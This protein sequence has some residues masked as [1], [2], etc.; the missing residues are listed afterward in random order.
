MR[1][2]LVNGKGQIFGE[3]IESDK[4]PDSEANWKKESGFVI[5]EVK[6]STIENISLK[7]PKDV[8]SYLKTQSEE[9]GI[10]FSDLMNK[11]IMEFVKNQEDFINKSSI[12][13]SLKNNPIELEKFVLSKIEKEIPLTSGTEGEIYKLEI[14]NK[15]YVVIKKRYSNM[16]KN[17]FELLKKAKS[18]Q[19]KISASGNNIKIPI[20][21]GSFVKDNCEYIMMEYIEGKT[22]YTMTLEKILQQD[23]VNYSKQIID[24]NKFKDYLSTIIY[25]MKG[26]EQD[27]INNFHDLS[28]EEILKNITN[29]HGNFKNIDLKNDSISEFVLLHFYKFLYDNRLISK[30]P[31]LLNTKKENVFLVDKYKTYLDKGISV[32][33]NS[34][35]EQIRK[36]ISDFIGK[37]H[38]EGFYHRDL[39]GN[40]R[41]IM[42]KEL[43]NGKYEIYI[44][45]FGKAKE[46]NGVDESVYEDNIAGG[47]F[48]KDEAIISLIGKLSGNK[49]NLKL[50]D[51]ETFSKEESLVK[52]GIEKYKLN[53]STFSPFIKNIISS[54]NKFGLKQVTNIIEKHDVSLKKSSEEYLFLEGVDKIK[55]TEKLKEAIKDSNKLKNRLL[56]YMFFMEDTDF[57]SLGEYI[58]KLKFENIKSKSKINGYKKFFIELYEDIKKI[59]NQK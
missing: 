34:K 3:I 2:K 17:E 48:D 18:I 25:F 37:M 4:K 15:N 36:E 53:K 51:K 5:E 31:D 21:I 49:N 19:E 9:N 57:I 23:F 33:D 16:H 14:Q 20:P 8:L 29:K 52:L 55:N 30:N 11:A 39:G 10:S 24:E 44:I 59:R 54:E 56:G 45:D 13:N 22:L 58:N 27:F 50:Y 47:I 26:L 1:G 46:T 40:P 38:K 12:I 35:G 6:K 32:F 42:F 41:N 28:K 43:L 7:M